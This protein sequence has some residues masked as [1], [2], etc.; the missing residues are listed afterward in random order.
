MVNPN[1]VIGREFKVFRMLL[2]HNQ[3]ELI[4]DKS[5]LFNQLYWRNWNS[6]HS[7]RKAGEHY[8]VG[9]QSDNNTW[10]GMYKDLRVIGYK[11]AASATGMYSYS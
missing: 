6:S 1:V 5:H 3:T 7:V 11:S 10:Y 8:A 9:K 4:N 2:L